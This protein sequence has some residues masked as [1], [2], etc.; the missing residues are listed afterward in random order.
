[1]DW[2]RRQAANVP[3]MCFVPWQNLVSLSE[4][5]Q[6]LEEGTIFPELV[7]PFLGRKGCCR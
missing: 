3:A 1:M 4:P 5:Q 6:A 7:K 2:R